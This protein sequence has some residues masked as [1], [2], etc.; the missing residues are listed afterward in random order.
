MK[1]Y[2]CIS[3]LN[4]PEQIDEINKHLHTTGIQDSHDIALG[5]SIDAQ[6]VT[7]LGQP[8]R[9][10][11]RS[12][13]ELTRMNARMKPNARMSVHIDCRNYNA[14]P[15]NFHDLDDLIARHTVPFLSDAIAI[16]DALDFKKVHSFQINGTPR[17]YEL[18]QFKN[19]ISDTDII[20]A[21]SKELVALGDTAVL[22]HIEACR[23]S[24][25]HVLIDLSAGRGERAP[26][27]EL[28]RLVRL[29]RTA[30]PDVQI[31]IAGRL[32]PADIRE[33]YAQHAT[34]ST[35]LSIDAETLLRNPVD[36][37]ISIQHVNLWLDNAQQATSL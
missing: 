16:A 1:P 13:M 19:R 25:G 36:D 22:A 37:T 9:R 23:T 6:T 2:I 32:G 27:E 30:A 20:Y 11:L 14:S 35:P 5:V 18:A 24:I 4:S 8:D 26:E 29:V 3:A 15:K 12:L 7:G 34:R 31:G 28:R 21:L 33:V 17:I 10:K